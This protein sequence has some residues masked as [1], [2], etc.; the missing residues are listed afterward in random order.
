MR[1]HE[2]Q[3][4]RDRRSNGGEDPRGGRRTTGRRVFHSSQNGRVGPEGVEAAIERGKRYLDAG[5]D[6]IYVE[7]PTSVEELSKIG[8][9][10][11]DVPLATSVLERGGKTPALSVQEF[12]QLHFDMLL[13]PTTILFRLTRAIEL[14][15]ADLRAS[16]P[17]STADSVDMD[18]FEDIVDLPFWAK[19]EKEFGGQEQ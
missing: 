1:A 14:A 17:L 13:Y 15:V 12:G 11:Q 19:I 3:E 16:R 9:Q 4:D 10:F 5:A 8:Q 6:G 2:R 18:Q 7:G